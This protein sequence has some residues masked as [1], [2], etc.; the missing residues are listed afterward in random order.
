MTK[1]RHTSEDEETQ[2]WRQNEQ[3]IKTLKQYKE[4][5]RTISDVKLQE[6]KTFMDY[7][8]ELGAQPAKA[9]LCADA[10]QRE[11]DTRTDNQ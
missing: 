7:M 8:L 1:K 6:Y 11:I 10:I 4:H 9:R 2:P 5:I 3:P